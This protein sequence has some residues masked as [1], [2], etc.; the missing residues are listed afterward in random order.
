[1]IFALL[2]HG[3]GAEKWTL[4]GLLHSSL[5]DL[6][7]KPACIHQSLSIELQNMHKDYFKH[8]LQTH[9]NQRYITRHGSI[10]HGST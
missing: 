7:Q 1:M 2:F 3:P 10:I 4:H 8:N 6:A 9:M 5:L